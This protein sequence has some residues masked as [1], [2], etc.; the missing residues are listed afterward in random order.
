MLRMNVFGR[1][2]LGDGLGVMIDGLMDLDAGR[3][4]SVHDRFADITCPLLMIWGAQD[5]HAKLDQ[6]RA[7]AQ[8]A[9]NARFVA[10]DRCGDVPHIEHP[11][12]VVAPVRE[13]DN[14]PSKA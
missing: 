4:W 1:P 7:A 8:S 9:P 12:V 6:A 11:D 10:L 3:P 5:P 14:R 13:F 2:G